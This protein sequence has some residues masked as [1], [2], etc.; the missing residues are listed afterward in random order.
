VS[1]LLS[2]SPSLPSLGDVGIAPAIDLLALGVTPAGQAARRSPPL[3]ASDAMLDS[4]EL[5][6]GEVD[7]ERVGMRITSKSSLSGRLMTD[8]APDALVSESE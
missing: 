7:W 8:M 1:A 3:M 6:F 5:T 2:L 4:S